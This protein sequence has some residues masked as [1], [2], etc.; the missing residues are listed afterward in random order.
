MIGGYDT[1]LVPNI[2][3]V[4]WYTDINPVNKLWQLDIKSVQYNKDIFY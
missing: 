1:D 2:Q 4:K 3:R